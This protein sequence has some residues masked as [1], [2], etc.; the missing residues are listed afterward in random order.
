[1][2]R[3][4]CLAAVLATT[5]SED[6]GDVIS[7]SSTLK[8][9]TSV[10]VKELTDRVPPEMKISVTFKPDVCQITGG[11]RTCID[12][13]NPNEYERDCSCFEGKEEHNEPFEAVIQ[14][15]LNM[16]AFSVVCMPNATGHYWTLLMFR[17]NRTAEETGEN[18]NFYRTIQAF[19]AQMGKLD[20]GLRQ[21]DY[22]MG[23]DN[24][25]ALTNSAW[26]YMM[27]LS[28]QPSRDDSNGEFRA[29]GLYDWEAVFNT[30]RIAGPNDNFRMTVKERREESDEMAEKF[31]RDSDN[32]FFSA[33]GGDFT[34]EEDDCVERHKAGWWFRPTKYD[35]YCSKCVPTGNLDRDNTAFDRSLKHVF[36]C[37]RKGDFEYAKEMAM[38]VYPRNWW[39]HTHS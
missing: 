26:N 15:Q 1:M 7:L 32:F 25:Y 10:K 31:I 23:L 18:T 16:P 37:D 33:K 30:F 34:D 22:W 11:F 27:R 39:S 21:H 35:E 13:N 4:V 3:W 14:P 8:E 2:L 17:R 19:R 5:V 36:G 29:K 24:M 38:A 9:I 28:F 6:P 12:E 20:T